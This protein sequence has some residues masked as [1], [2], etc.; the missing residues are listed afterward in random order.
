MVITYFKRF[1]NVKLNFNSNFIYLGKAYYNHFFYDF[2]LH[3]L[4]YEFTSLLLCYSYSALGSYSLES[5]RIT[6]N[7]LSLIKIILAKL[8]NIILGSII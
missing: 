3:L 1:N 2:S 4:K 7:R 6:F 5:K 8:V